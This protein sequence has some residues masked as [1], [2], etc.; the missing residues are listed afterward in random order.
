MPQLINK[1]KI[2]FYIFCFIFLTTITNQKFILFVKNFFLIDNIV[3]KIDKLNANEKKL[4]KFNS[5]INK[6]IFLIKKEDFFT[7]LNETKYL[8][9]II[10]KKKI[11][12]NNNCQSKKNE[13]CSFNIF[14]PKKILYWRK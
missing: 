6:N 8:Q 2:Y 5:L 3:I 13:Y 9:D 12:I 10:I 11:S 4:F 14:K 7:Y 1:N